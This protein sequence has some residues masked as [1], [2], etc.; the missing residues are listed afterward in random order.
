MDA[1]N[2]VKGEGLRRQNEDLAAQELT[3]DLFNAL[4]ENLVA[5]WLV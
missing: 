4:R 2:R 1:T 3:V 5:L